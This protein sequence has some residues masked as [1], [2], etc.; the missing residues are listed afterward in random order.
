MI[1]SY[2]IKN[3]YSHFEYKELSKIDGEPTLDSIL[4]LHR[5][6]KRNAQ[7]VAT[8][9]G[10]GQL[11]YLALV[12]TEEQYNGI[13]NAE[14]FVRPTNP[15]DFQLQVPDPN[16][17]TSPTTR[18]TV[19][20]SSTRLA[21]NRSPS[22]QETTALVPTENSNASVITAAEVATQK[23]AHEGELKKY[24]ECQAVEQALRTQIIE[25]VEADYL[26][27]LRNVNTDMINETIPEIFD[28]LQTN[29][30]QVTEE[31]MVTKEDDLKNYAY[32]PKA[33]VD[34]VFTQIATFQDL[35]LITNN[36][37]TD[38]QLCQL[39]YLIFHRTRTFQDSLKI[40]NATPTE[41]KTFANFKAHMRKEHQSLK[42]VGALTVQSSALYQANMLQQVANQQSDLEQNLKAT[43]DEQVK[44]SMMEALA[45][46]S[47]EIFIDDN[48]HQEQV[49]NVAVPKAPSIMELFTMMSELNKKVDTLAEPKKRNLTINPRTGKPF[50]RYCHSCGCCDH[51]GKTCINKKPGH[52]DNAT[53]KNRMGGS[54]ANCLP[55]RE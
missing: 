36:G 48:D 35:C 39:A 10:G 8:T 12:L 50:R 11:G 27:A 46:Y 41:N 6:V 55:N 5:Q 53:F 2:S 16:T 37:K 49:N 33:P 34:K 42:Q 30:G 15:G 28:Y 18:R 4:L 29:Y 44:N 9:L 47:Q 20:R 13:P 24:Y 38:K 40:W 3:I 25:A 1:T 32:D 7:C 31:E 51:W 23:A 21:A 14:Q 17:T 43:V 22:T 52:Q 54:D 45:Q 26:D 19:T